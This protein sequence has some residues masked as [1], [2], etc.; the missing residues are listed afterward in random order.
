MLADKSGRKLTGA[1]L[2]RVNRGN[3]VLPPVEWV[4]LG[5]EYSHLILINYLPEFTLYT[6]FSSH[7]HNSWEWILMSPFCRCRNRGSHGSCAYLKV[8]WLIRDQIAPPQNHDLC[9]GPGQFKLSPTVNRTRLLKV[10]R[11]WEGEPFSSAVGCNHCWGRILS[12]F[13]L[14][15][16][17]K[18]FPNGSSLPDFLREGHTDS[19][20]ARLFFSLKKKKKRETLGN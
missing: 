19:M 9:D 10:P 5:L 3:S 18:V 17:E 12:S 8:I 4:G 1:G 16:L 11:P 7:R 6:V 15:P 2:A 20:S 14:T 13:Y